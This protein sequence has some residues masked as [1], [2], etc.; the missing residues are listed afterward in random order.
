MSKKDYYEILGVSRDV[1]EEELKKAYR[2]LAVKYHPDKNPGDKAAEEHFKE[3]AHAYEMLS[4]PDKRRKYDQYGEAAFQY[5]GAG[6]GGFHDPF[7]VFRDVFSGN[8]GDMF[9]DVFGFGGG[10][11]SRRGHNRGRDLEYS[12]KLE[13]MEAVNGVEKEINVRRFEAC[14]ACSGSGAKKG[15]GHTTC[16]RCGGS[17]MIRQSAG[18]FSISQTCGACSG[19]G[20]VIKD[21][22]S[23]CGGSGRKENTRKIKVRI[24]AGVDNGI[25]V[26][27]SG[28]GEAGLNGGPSGDL[29]VSMSVKKHEVFSREEFDIYCA[30]PVSFAE[31]VLGAEIEIPTISGVTTVTIPAGTASGHVFRLKGL[32]VTRLDGRGKG[33][34]FVKIEVEIPHGLSAEQKRLLN[35]FNDSISKNKDYMSGAKKIVD[36]IKKVFE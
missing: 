33:D 19:T 3:I 25:R 13:F 32:G 14:E 12:I 5:G 8:F 2:K 10:S 16:Q 23:S 21:P 11:G 20:K 35:E 6:A 24:P 22:C 34:E 28:E 15:S 30:I 31:L 27:L 26:R 9:G 18:F 17:G 4:D 36:K 29:Y 1:S 7:D